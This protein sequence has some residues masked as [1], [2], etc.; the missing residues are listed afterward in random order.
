MAVPLSYNSSARSDYLELKAPYYN[1]IEP[2]EIT[3]EK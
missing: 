2:S 3:F 1:A